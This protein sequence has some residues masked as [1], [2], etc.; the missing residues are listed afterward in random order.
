MLS[1]REREK[2]WWKEKI[3]ERVRKR[4]GMRKREET[5]SARLVT[6]KEG[7]GGMVARLWE[8]GYYVCERLGREG[9]EEGILGDIDRFRVYSHDIPG[10]PCCCGW[11][12][13]PRDSHIWH[14][15]SLVRAASASSAWDRIVGLSVY[16]NYEWNNG[17]IDMIT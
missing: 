17:A 15:Y 3:V 10:Q 6:R 5:G 7:V 12:A 9:G 11:Y 14:A 13:L 2:W 8:R 1:S 4:E 16:G